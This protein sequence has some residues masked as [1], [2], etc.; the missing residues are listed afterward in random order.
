MR[1]EAT[2]PG[3]G[4]VKVEA[5]VVDVAA[6]LWER[7]WDCIGD[8]HHDDQRDAGR[9]GERRRERSLGVAGGNG[10]DEASLRS[11]ACLPAQSEPS[12]TT[13]PLRAG[14]RHTEWFLPLRAITIGSW[15]GN[16]QRQP[17]ATCVAG[18]IWLTH[19]ERCD[20][21]PRASRD[22]RVACVQGLKRRPHTNRK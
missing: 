20:K 18:A 22:R 15:I 10:K 8:V 14:S 9:G 21:R 7:E 5:R 12:S 2:S 4:R 13:S 16:S 17:A 19:S 6:N 1:R 3:L 11:V